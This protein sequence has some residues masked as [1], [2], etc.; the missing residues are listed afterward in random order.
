MEK[1]EIKNPGILSKTV[2]INRFLAMSGVTSRRKAEELILQGLVTINGKTVTDL[3]T[4]VRPNFDNVSVENKVILL[5]QTKIYIVFNKPKD[6]I[7]TTKDEKGRTTVFD[8][9][10]SKHRIFPVGRLDRNTTGVLLL[11]ND[12]DFAYQ[13]MHP[14]YEIEKTYHVTLDKS[15][16]TKDIKRVEGGIILERKKTAK[17]KVT[18]Y[19]KTH[20]RQFAITIHEGRN[21][22]IR[23]MLEILGYDVEKLDRV[24]YG[25]ITPKGIPRGGWR[26]LTNPEMR[27]LKKMF[28]KKNRNDD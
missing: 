22:Q 21:R 9:V 6:C 16:D 3:A 17:A 11:T 12:G 19:P 28:I 13:L 27:Q 7:T 1:M 4:K 2:R 8:Y 24:S 15:L 26:Y 18:L 25:G 5:E 10:R 14:S 23:K 20:N